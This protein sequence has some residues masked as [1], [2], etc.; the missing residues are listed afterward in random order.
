MDYTF[1]VVAL[2]SGG[3]ITDGLRRG[4]GDQRIEDSII[5]F[6]CVSTNIGRS[7]SEIHT[8]GAM[9]KSIRASMAIP[10]IFL[11]V[12]DDDRLLVDGGMVNNLPVDIMQAYE[13]IGTAVALDVSGPISVNTTVPMDGY[14]SGW[15]VLTHW[16][17][18]AKKGT[19]LAPTRQHRDASG[20]D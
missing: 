19:K 13:D 14:F 6:F 12:V 7:A 11:P 3:N 15:Q 20:T 10:G 1:P 18:P 5:N 2:A 9:W 17:N 4:F 16:L 8:R